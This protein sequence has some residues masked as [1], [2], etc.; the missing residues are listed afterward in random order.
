[1]PNF[2]IGEV[3]SKQVTTATFHKA[4]DYKAVTLKGESNPVLLHKIHA[5]KL[6]KKELAEY[7]KDVKVKENAPEITS[8]VVD[9]TT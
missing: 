7:A 6:V 3:A 4:S 2:N 9:K 1:M 5:E 8:T